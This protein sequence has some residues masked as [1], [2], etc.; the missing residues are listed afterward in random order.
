VSGTVLRPNYPIATERLLLRPFEPGDLDALLAIHGDPQVTRY[1]YW[2]TRGRDELRDV[3]AEK[4][5]RTALA[6]EGDGLN[7]AAVLKRTGE[8]VGD[9][10]LFWR[11]REHRQGEVGYMLDPAHGGR[12]YATEAVRELLRIGF[13]ELGLHRITGQLDA[14]N[15]AS[16]RVLERLG[17]RREAHLVENEFVKGEWTSGL[18][19][20]LLE[21]EW[22][23]ARAAA[24]TARTAA[25]R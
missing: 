2:E 19:Y 21:R 4:L 16:A 5:G 25:P 12:G 1:L 23:E 7:L 3:L 15:E 17:M 11:S 9:V 14:R 24:L 20:A 13:E 22:R 6:D 8:L 10:V 18:V